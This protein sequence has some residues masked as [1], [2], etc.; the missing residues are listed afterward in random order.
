MSENKILTALGHPFGGEIAATMYSG[1]KLRQTDKNAALCELA[2]KFDPKTDNAYISGPTGCGKTHFATAIMTR[3]GGR[4]M[5]P[6]HL[7]RAARIAANDEEINE[8]DFTGLFVGRKISTHN[9][10]IAPFDTFAIDD[11]GTEKL[12]EWS[13]AIL[14][15]IIDSRIMNGMGGMVITS[16]LKLDDLAARTGSDRIASRIAGM[17]KVFN[18]VGEKDGRMMKATK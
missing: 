4:I 3:H 17:S 1:D 18:L 8:G 15:E 9:L 2:L 11:L 14:F 7:F 16:N 5:K 13:E 10:Y 12:T 6:Y